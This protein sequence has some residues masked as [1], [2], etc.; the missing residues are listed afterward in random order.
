MDFRRSLF[1][2][3]SNPGSG[4]RQTDRDI[5]SLAVVNIS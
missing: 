1:S 5:T 2:I 3:L 4:N